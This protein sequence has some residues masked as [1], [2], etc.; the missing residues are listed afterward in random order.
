[1][2][3]F[4]KKICNVYTFKIFMYNINYININIYMEIHGNIFKI[5]TVCVCLYI[6][7]INIH[8]IHVNKNFYFGC[9]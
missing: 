3:I 8:S 4:K 7:I 5:Y 6:Y 2:Y 9:D 1:M